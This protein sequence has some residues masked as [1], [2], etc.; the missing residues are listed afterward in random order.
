[1]DVA[2]NVSQGST[3]DYK[4]PLLQSPPPLRRASLPFFAAYNPPTHTLSVLLDTDHSEA[5]S[6][7]LHADTGW[8]PAA[9]TPSFTTRVQAAT[10]F[11]HLHETLK[12]RIFLINNMKQVKFL[13]FTWYITKKTRVY[14]IAGLTMIPW[15]LQLSM[16]L[17]PLVLE[18]LSLTSSWHT[19]NSPALYCLSNLV[20]FFR[21]KVIMCSSSKQTHC[22]HNTHEYHTSP[23]LHIW[24]LTRVKVLPLPVCLWTQELV[25]IFYPAPMEDMLTSNAKTVARYYCSLGYR[26]RKEPVYTNTFTLVTLAYIFYVKGSFVM[27]IVFVYAQHCRPTHGLV[28]CTVIQ[29]RFHMLF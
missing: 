10:H 27:M 21:N 19:P 1:M 17:L 13:A 24:P 5:Q 7:N 2:N 25:T 11:P 12:A 14:C 4:H 15:A 23:H 22:C 20:L 6:Y 28:T 3:G 9:A 26:V 29:F 18:T 16:N 8:V